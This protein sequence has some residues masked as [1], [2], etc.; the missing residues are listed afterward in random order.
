MSSL[1]EPVRNR[2]R[3][4]ARSSAAGLVCA[5]ALAV[6][7]AAVSTSFAQGPAPPQPPPPPGA[8]APPET[9]TAPGEPDTGEPPAGE[10][11]AG[12][13][14]PSDAPAQSGPA[15]LD[16]FPVVVVAGRQGMRSTRVS[17]LSVR[18]PREARVVVRC[19]GEQCPM[20]RA[21][22][23]IPRTK[24]VRVTKAERVYPAGLVIEVRVTG[25]DRVGKYTRI[26]FRRGRTPARSDACL[27]PGS[28]RPSACPKS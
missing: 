23:T 16:P 19:L 24:R 4:T 2:S 18:G 28:S 11:P 6:A 25:R 14:S 9:P 7:A 1:S 21:A 26:R 12:E 22:A 3:R 13:P 27:Q 17:E 5:L 8:P 15:K 10:P 20:R